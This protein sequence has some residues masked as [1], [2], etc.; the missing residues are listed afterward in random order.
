ML[1]PT[2]PGWSLAPVVDHADVSLHDP[3]ERTRLVVSEL[4]GPFEELRL[5]QWDA[6]IILCREVLC[7]KPRGGCR[8]VIRDGVVRERQG[9]DDLVFQNVHVKVCPTRQSSLPQFHT[10]RIAVGEL[11]A[12][13]FEGTTDRFQRRRGASIRTGLDLADHI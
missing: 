9:D 11:D 1:G 6:A 7:E 3:P 4:P 2:D 5:G 13:I 8:L 10:W 12:S